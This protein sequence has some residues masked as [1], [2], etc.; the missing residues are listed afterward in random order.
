MADLRTPPHPPLPCMKRRSLLPLMA[1]PLAAPKL[2]HA[3]AAPSG[4]VLLLVTGRLRH[5]NRHDGAAFDMAMLAQLPQARL[6]TRTPW[7]PEPREFTGPLL[8]D[9]LAAAGAHGQAL[10]ARALNDYQVSIPMDDVLQHDV[11]LARL[12]DGAP[13]AV[14]DKG[15]LLIMYPFDQKPALR[16][17]LYY[18]RCAWQLQAIEVA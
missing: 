4:P 8:R 14:R 6:R 5:S 9:V 18:T 10:R 7:Y 3:L 2:A 15:P 12:L 13:L 1:W 11:V 16:S 17:T